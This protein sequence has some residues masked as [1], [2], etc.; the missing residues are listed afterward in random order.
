MQKEQPVAYASRTLNAAERN[1]AQIEKEMLGIVYGLHKC[2][3]YVYGK[4][5][6]V[7]TEHKPLES[8]F[9]SLSPTNFLKIRPPDLFV[10]NEYLTKIYRLFAKLRPRNLYSFKYNEYLL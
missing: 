7:E 4:T 5:V 2:N 8:L 9:K 1:Y 6:L 3:E 10:S